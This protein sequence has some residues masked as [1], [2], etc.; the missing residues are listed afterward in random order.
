MRISRKA[1]DRMVEAAI[2]SLPEEFAAWLE[3]VP[4]IVEDRPGK[5]DRGVVTEDGPPLG[6][7]VGASRLE[8]EE[9]GGGGGAGERRCR[10]G[11]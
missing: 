1:F 9:G 11:S 4:V 7:Y 2:E 10:R 8:G 5:G 3:E 6:L